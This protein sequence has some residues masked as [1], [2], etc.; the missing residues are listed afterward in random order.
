MKS[1]KLPIGDVDVEELIELID[2]DKDGKVHSN[3]M[4]NH[5]LTILRLISQNSLKDSM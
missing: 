5:K 4:I 2:Q 3:N 1:G